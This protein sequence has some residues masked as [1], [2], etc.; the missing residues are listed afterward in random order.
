MKTIELTT[1]CDDPDLTVSSFRDRCRELGLAI[2]RDTTMR[3]IPNSV[4]LHL[5]GSGERSGTLE[6]TM[7]RESGRSWLSFHENRFRPWIL[8]AIDKLTGE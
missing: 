2:T 8:A 7:D 6:Y 5:R 4:H 3:T 1:A